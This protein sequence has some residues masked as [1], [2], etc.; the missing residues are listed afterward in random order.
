[1]AGCWVCATRAA[2]HRNPLPDSSDD[3]AV[4]VEQAHGGRTI[5]KLV[6]DETVGAHAGV[7]VAERCRQLRVAAPRVVGR[8]EQEVVAV[9]VCL[10]YAHRLRM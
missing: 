9:G 1:M 7:P 10:D 4:G 6:Q 2:R 5:A 3:T 8:N